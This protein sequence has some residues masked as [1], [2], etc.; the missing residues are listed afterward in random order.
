M[1]PTLARANNDFT[2]R[3]LQALEDPS[4]PRNYFFSPYS[5]HSA[6]SLAMNGA[7][8]AT[9]HAMKTGLGWGRTGRPTINRTY[10][11]LRAGLENSA[12]QVTLGV[13]N[14]VWVNQG[15]ELRADF[16]QQASEYYAA[17]AERVDF[18]DPATR[19]HI[20]VWI[21]QHTCDRIT[22]L[23][24]P[25]HLTPPPVAALVNAI[26]FKGLWQAPF[27]PARTQPAPFTLA[28]GTQ[29]TVPLMQRSGTYAYFEG[30]D[31]QLASLPYGGPDSSGDFCLDVCLPAPGLPLADWVAR[32]D[33]R[34]WQTWIERMDE[35]A[36]ELALPRFSLRYEAGLTEPLARLGLGI[37][38]SA[39]AD[40]SDLCSGPAVISNVIHGAFVEVNEEGSEAAAATVVVMLRGA[41]I[42]RPK[43]R[44][45]VDRPFFC[46]IRHRP[47]GTILFAGLVYEP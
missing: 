36:I 47:S 38:F 33:E 2:F 26:Y 42:A 7:Q 30:P 18:S 40:F 1:T 35:T 31:F 44:L 28:D 34:A 45:I 27:D 21:A 19:Q 46:A 13:A 14:A 6:L 23:L 20:N 10:A 25:E 15:L 12:S 3:L 16:E 32:L 22:E 11:A 43:P 41:L 8:G 9:L 5:I 37:A 39:Q 29:K 17:L 4:S 24:K